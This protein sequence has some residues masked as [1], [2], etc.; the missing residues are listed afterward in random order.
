MSGKR[1]LITGAHGMLGTALIRYAFND[2][3]QFTKE[4]D[5]SNSHVLSK[6]LNKYNTDI[7]IH[8][9]AFT[10]VEACEVDI[11]KAYKINTIGTQNLVNYCI[12]KDIL[13]IYISSTG[14]YGIAKKIEPY[15]E[16][17]DLSPTTVHHKT[18]VEAEHIIQNHL[19]KYLI[20]RTGWLYGGDINHAKNFVYKR[21]LEANEKK[22]IYS[23]D[24]QLGN[25][26][27]VKDLTQ[28]IKL[29]IDKQQYG[30]FNCVN[31]A[32]G[33]S[34]YAYVKKII[35]LFDIDCEVKVATHKMFNRIAPVSS[36]ESA[37]NYKLELLNLNIMDNW[38]ESLKQYIEELKQEL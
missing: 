16:F 35:E 24:S 34:R 10:D 2:A 3:I 38:Q 9:A 5:I 31:Q 20:I 30:I 19:S 12:G 23:D 26:T 28:Q 15:T 6:Q 27:F 8:T 21:Y 29:L 17:D 1:V 22:L 32:K 13:F 11:D 36:N 14:N 33:I 37:R 4:I 25:P 7:I 18:K